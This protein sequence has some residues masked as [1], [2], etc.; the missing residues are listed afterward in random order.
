MQKKIPPAL[1]ARGNSVITTLPSSSPK[2]KA[3]I[4]NPEKINLEKTMTDNEE[5]IKPK[6]CDTKQ[7]PCE[8]KNCREPSKTEVKDG[9]NTNVNSSDSSCA[10]LKKSYETDMI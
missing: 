3:P 4:A 2:N 1:P 9:V 10:T 8:E 6:H 7:P 5:S